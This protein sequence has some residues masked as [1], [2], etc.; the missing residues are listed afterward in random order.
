VD[1]IELVIQQKEK[2]EFGRYKTEQIFMAM[3][4]IQSTQANLVME[5]YI[6]F[7]YFDFEVQI[8]H[9]GTW[10]IIREFLKICLQVFSSFNPPF[11]AIQREVK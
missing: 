7:T 5:V 11:G 9:V 6:S 3:S 2:H 1:S 8:L 4:V 10:T